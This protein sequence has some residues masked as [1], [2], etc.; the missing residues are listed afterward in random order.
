MACLFANDTTAL[1]KLVPPD[2]IVWSEYLVETETNGK[3]S[4]S[5]GPASEI[6]VLCQG[7]WTNRGWHT[8]EGNE[9]CV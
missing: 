5:S 6:F 7:Q 3:R 2:T 8:D 4:L 1:A 9:H